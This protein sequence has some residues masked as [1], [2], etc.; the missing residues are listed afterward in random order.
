MRTSEFG[1][2]AACKH[3]TLAGQWRLRAGNSRWA[4]FQL[5]AGF[6]RLANA[7]TV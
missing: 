6:R 2:L 4:A 7:Q 1:T 3:E 5:L